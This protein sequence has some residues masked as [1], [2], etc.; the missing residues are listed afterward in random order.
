MFLQIFLFY[1]EGLGGRVVG[2]ENNIW[3]QVV[4]MGDLFLNIQIHEEC[5]FQKL[6]G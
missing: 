4:K 3:I 5:N 1:Y 2:R 6:S